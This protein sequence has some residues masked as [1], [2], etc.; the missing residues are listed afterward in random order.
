MFIGNGNT[1]NISMNKINVNYTKTCI[2]FLMLYLLPMICSMIICI[3][4]LFFNNLYMNKLTDTLIYHNIHSTALTI[5][6]R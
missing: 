5:V 2:I 3:L 1:T 6:P 4:F